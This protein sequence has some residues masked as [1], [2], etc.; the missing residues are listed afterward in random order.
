M[1]TPEQIRAARAMLN[2]KQSELAEAA[3][4]SL[5]TL[6]NIERGI[7]DPRASTIHAIESALA[8]GGIECDQ[9]NNRETI[10]LNKY[11]RPTVYDSFSGSQKVLEVLSN[12]NLL[13]IE[14]VIFYLRKDNA[15]HTAETQ[16]FVSILINGPIRKVL[17][18]QVAFTLEGTARIAEVAGILY[19]AMVKNSSHI[20][21][22]DT[23][24]DDTSLS[25]VDVAVQA[26]VSHEK[27]LLSD[28]KS[29]F[30]L[31]ADWD[32]HFSFAATTPNH[33][34]KALLS[35]VT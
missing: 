24:L 15:H 31:Y 29:F 25:P 20:Y 2:I 10:T 11:S 27:K 1:I 6:N 12:E 30:S 3:G 18:D 8:V 16:P 5:A 9:D 4:I 14:E 7:G 21:Y 32:V 22:I 35:Y 19:A 17:F 34:L 13:K 28:P 26:L 23:I 33:P